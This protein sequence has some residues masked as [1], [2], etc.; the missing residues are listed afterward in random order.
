LL[1]QK[2]CD[3]YWPED[4]EPVVY[5]DIQVVLVSETSEGSKWTIKKLELSVVNVLLTET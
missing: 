3:Q 5:G 2:K 4:T 1:L